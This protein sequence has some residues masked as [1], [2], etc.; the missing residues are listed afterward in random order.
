MRRSISALVIVACL[1]LLIPRPTLAY[2]TDLVFER[3]VGWLT[4]ISGT[5]A[6][7][8]V[9]QPVTWT[10]RTA[11]T[12]GPR[13]AVPGGQYLPDGQFEFR[14]ETNGTVTVTIYMLDDQIDYRA[15][16]SLRNLSTGDYSLPV[17]ESDRISRILIGLE[18]DANQSQVTLA[19]LRFVQGI[20]VTPPAPPAGFVAEAAELSVILRWLPNA[21]ADLAEYVVYVDGN[22]HA[23]TT[24]TSHVVDGL[25]AGVPVTVGVAARDRTGNESAAVTDTVIPLAPLQPPDAPR[26][27]RVEVGSTALILRWDPPLGSPVESYEVYRD[28]GLVGQTAQT[29][30]RETQLQPGTQYEYAV[31]AQNRA[32]RSP[33]ATITALTRLPAP[34]HRGV[35][36]D[37]SGLSDSVREFLAALR[38]VWIISAG[39]LLASVLLSAGMRWIGGRRGA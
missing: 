22:E 8:L 20:D 37:L 23:T 26:A 13:Y 32:G 2:S 33:A 16:Y 12:G 35:R 34:L 31:I 25:P 21:E 1:M 29:L 6:G 14:I 24:A 7:P 9:G 27:L 5:W 17:R 11:V 15:V 28:G 18:G 36:V 39:I 4:L 38:P 10:K 19:Y 3:T 30:W